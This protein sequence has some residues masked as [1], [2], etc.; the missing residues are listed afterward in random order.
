MVAEE[1]EPSREAS[2]EVLR[3]DPQKVLAEVDTSAPLFMPAHHPVLAEDVDMGRLG[4][5]LRIAHEAQPENFEGA[6]GLPGV[7]PKTIRSLAL[8]AEL[9]FNAPVSRR[10]PATSSYA[11][12]GKDG[13]PFPV[14]RDLYD[15]N[16]A[17]LE[18]AVAKSGVAPDDKDSALR[19]LARFVREEGPGRQESETR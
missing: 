10:D 8:I 3:I 2:V 11:H 7:G 12:G 15:R 13:H 16:I 18:D 6:L 1:A 9:I 4:K 5:I 19:R 17:V 14:D